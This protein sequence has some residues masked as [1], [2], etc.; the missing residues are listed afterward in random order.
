MIDKSQYIIIDIDEKLK[1]ELFD[2]DLKK[3]NQFVINNLREKIDSKIYKTLQIK[4]VKYD[5]SNFN[6]SSRNNIVQNILVDQ[7]NIIEKKE[8]NRSGKEYIR[9]FD[10]SKINLQE[11]SRESYNYKM[12]SFEEFEIPD[13]KETE[14]CNSCKGQ[15]QNICTSCNGAGTERCSSCR[16]GGQIRCSS[17]S[18]KGQT[19]C[20]W[21]WGKGYSSKGERCFACSGKGYN[22]CSN[23]QNGYYTCNSCSGKGMVS[24]YSC[25][26]TRFKTCYNCSGYKSFVYRYVVESNII[27]R[28]SNS[29]KISNVSSLI[30]KLIDS[31]EFNYSKTFKD[32]ELK[33][34]EKYKSDIKNL[35]LLEKFN[36]Q[37]F[38]KKIRFEQYQSLDVNFEINYFDSTYLCGISSNGIYI[39]KSFIDNLLINLITNL[40]IDENFDELISI[41]NPLVNLLPSF[42]EIFK[43][44][45]SYKKFHKIIKSENSDEIKI[46]NVK[47]IKN[48]ESQSFKE[49]LRKSINKKYTKILLI[50]TV[51]I[52]AILSFLFYAYSPYI[53]LI[54][55][56]IFSLTFLITNEHLFNERK[57]TLK[58]KNVFSNT[59]IV[60]SVSLLCLFYY[61]YANEFIT[62]MNIKISEEEINLTTS[63]IKNEV[64]N[65]QEDENNNYFVDQIDLIDKIENEIKQVTNSNQKKENPDTIES[66]KSEKKEEIKDEEIKTVINGYNGE[67]LHGRRNGYGEMIYPNGDTYL[68]YWKDD[69]HE[70]TGSYTYFNGDKYVGNFNNNLKNGNGTF[71]YYKSKSRFQGVWENDIQKN[72][73]LFFNNGDYFKGDIDIP[74]EELNGYGIYTWRNGDYYE[75]SFKFGKKNGE[76][77]Y[78]WSDGAS[79]KGRWLNDKENGP[80][81]MIWS[82]G[83]SYRGNY[84]NGLRSGKGIH[85]YADGKVYEEEWF[86]GE[87]ISERRRRNLEK[88]N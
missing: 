15:G 88:R 69:K 70:G 10:K 33:K 67:I 45:Y 76:G 56:T 48:I 14:S 68:G 85:R 44:I 72:G 77:K 17:C 5:I 2:L 7:R 23:C 79:F 40:K 71:Y 60:I 57:N 75:G 37:E 8:T 54:F 39:E 38:P 53:I 49:D 31:E 24:C 58:I 35:F 52:C 74:G 11:Y 64:E 12:N 25:S 66:S 83:G 61:G 21:C 46:E 6:I 28:K 42:E 26:G 73:T 13:S 20:M 63:S 50:I 3:D 16:G 27:Y 65:I 84:I 22:I 81:L 18:G 78:Y 87:L 86:K 30:S 41:K 80:G 29:L 62:P 82:D 47:K 36:A 1:K 43:D 19:S 51:P 59:I 32:Y 55:I 4:L 34:I 9:T